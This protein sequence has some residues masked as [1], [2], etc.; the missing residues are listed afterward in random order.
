MLHQRSMY[1]FN[2]SFWFQIF[3]LSSQI[4][5]ISKYLSLPLQ[6]YTKSIWV[7][8]SLAT[9]TGNSCLLAF[10]SLKI[11]VSLF[12]CSI[13]PSRGRA[14]PCSHHL[15]RMSNLSTRY[16]NHF[17]PTHPSL[18]L[19]LFFLF[20]FLYFDVNCFICLVFCFYFV[21]VFLILNL[22]AKGEA[23]VIQPYF[24]WPK[25]M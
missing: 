13:N 1:S 7:S 17:C 15:H 14:S 16:Q 21:F 23:N 10:S 22:L 2:Q 4:F 8:M 20:L 5:K 25:L 6:Y 12:S 18:L 11:S 3:T 9:T 19:S 24:G